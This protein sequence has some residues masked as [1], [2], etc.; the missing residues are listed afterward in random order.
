MWSRMIVYVHPPISND[1]FY[2]L[3]KIPQLTTGFLNFSK[4]QNDHTFLTNNPYFF[5]NNSFFY[6]QRNIYMWCV[7]K[8][9]YTTVII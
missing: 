3:I 2:L 4:H 6:P 8:S 1:R 9:A 5:L 7:F